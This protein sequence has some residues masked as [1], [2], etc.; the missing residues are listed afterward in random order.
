MEDITSIKGSKITDIKVTKSL[1]K[2][3]LLTICS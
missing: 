3:T 1:N 2:K